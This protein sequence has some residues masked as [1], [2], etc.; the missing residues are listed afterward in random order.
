MRT[1]GS[2][3]HAWPGT[4]PADSV[5]CG[6]I[7]VCCADVDVALVDD[8]RRREADHAALPEGAEATAPSGVRTDRPE[9]PR[10]LQAATCSASA[11]HQLA[12]HHDVPAPR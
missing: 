6:P 4:I 10:P 12:T 3:R 5:T 2:V 9:P 11:D 1:T 7:I 8:R